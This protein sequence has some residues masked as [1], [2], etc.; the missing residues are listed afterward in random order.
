MR[1]F[2]PGGTSAALRWVTRGRLDQIQQRRGW[3]RIEIGELFTASTFP[4]GPL[5][6]HLPGGQFSDVVRNGSFVLTRVPG[7]R[8]DA[9]MTR[10]P[11]GGPPRQPMLTLIQIRKRHLDL[12]HYRRRTLPNRIHA[13]SLSQRQA[14]SAQ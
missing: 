5:Q 9:A 12:R 11:G 1:V 10:H 6:R 4:V 14:L 2:A 7:H 13:V 3:S 8:P